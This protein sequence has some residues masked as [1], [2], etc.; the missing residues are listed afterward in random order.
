MS[1]IKVVKL[2]TDDEIICGCEEKENSVVMENPIK[3]IQ[4]PREDGL[5]IAFMPWMV[6]SSEDSFEISRDKVLLVTNP[7]SEVK[8]EYNARFGSGLVVP[9]EKE[10]II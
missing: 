3:I 6:A 7:N 5:G 4:V 10:L 9:P 1:E 8:N 2:V